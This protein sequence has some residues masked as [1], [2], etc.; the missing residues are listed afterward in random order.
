MRHSPH[1]LLGVRTSL[2]SRLAGYAAKPHDQAMEKMTIKVT[3]VSAAA[4]FVNASLSVDVPEIGA[5]ARLEIRFPT[6]PGTG[7]D[8]WRELAYDRALMML[9][10]A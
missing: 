8:D 9:D 6:P 10:P 5:K 3:E 4:G 2:A 1:D 7:L